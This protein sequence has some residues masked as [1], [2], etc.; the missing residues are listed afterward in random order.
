MNYVTDWH[1]Q[2]VYSWQCFQPSTSQFRWEDIVV[3]YCTTH[4]SNSLFWHHQLV[5]DL[6]KLPPVHVSVLVERA[7]ANRIFVALGNDVSV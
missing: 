7:P 3:A 6:V 5:D 1:W 4:M 2:M